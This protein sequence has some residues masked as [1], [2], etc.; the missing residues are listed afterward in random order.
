MSG[1]DGRIVRESEPD[2]RMPCRVCGKPMRW[3]TREFEKFTNVAPECDEHG[4]RG[5]FTLKAATEETK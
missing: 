3:R 2:E 4:I 5:F 1:D